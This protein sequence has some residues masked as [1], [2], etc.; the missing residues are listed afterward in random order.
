MSVCLCVRVRVRVRVCVYKC[1]S[2]DLPSS[3][4]GL[5]LR[6]FLRCVYNEGVKEL[7]V[8]PY[9]CSAVS[10]CIHHFTAH[11]FLRVFRWPFCCEEAMG[12]DSL[13]YQALSFTFRVNAILSAGLCANL[14]KASS[15]WQQTRNERIVL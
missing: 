7:H 15:S 2:R 1:V 13:L 14:D 8:C 9:I 3:H 11:V 4:G 10:P 12:L 6:L 5:L